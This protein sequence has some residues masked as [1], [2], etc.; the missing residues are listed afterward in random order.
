MYTNI[1]QNIMKYKHA[2]LDADDN[3]IELYNQIINLKEMSNSIH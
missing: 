1:R 2:D 3:F